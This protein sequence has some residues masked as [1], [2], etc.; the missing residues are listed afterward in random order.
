[1]LDVVGR[2][3]VDVFYLQRGLFG[4]LALALLLQP[5]LL[6]F[7]ELVIF[8][9]DIEVLLLRIV[10]LLNN[11]TGCDRGSRESRRLGDDSRI[12]AWPGLRL[13]DKI[14]TLDG[15]LEAER[16]C[17]ELSIISQMCY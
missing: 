13:L 17:V 11:G 6:L 8:V 9:D 15:R 1:L 12:R 10:P 2:R 4:S 14:G 7:L 5:N 3:P 16:G